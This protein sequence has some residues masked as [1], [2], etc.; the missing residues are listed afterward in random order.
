MEPTLEIIKRLSKIE[1]FSDFAELSEAN[2]RRLNAVCQCLD[3]KEFKKGDVIIREGDKG[4]E[5]YIL[6]D[7][8]VQIKGKTPHDE[9]FAIIDL[10]H[11]Q[12]VFLGELALID[13]DR[14]S[15]SVYAKTDCKTLSLSGTDFLNLCEQDSLLGYKVLFKIAKRL[16]GNLRR[17]TSETLAM[18]QALIDE[19]ENRF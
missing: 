6:Y 18:Y 7:G 16:S 2:I 19:V 11:K 3:Q 12:N 15:A 8:A 9:E 1:I 13:Q 4:D 14:R 10:D 5:L 17:S